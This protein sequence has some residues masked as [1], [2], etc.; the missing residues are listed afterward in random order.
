MNP[1]T[2]TAEAERTIDDLSALIEKLSGLMEQETA[3]VHAGKVSVAVGLGQTKSELAHQLYMSGER[4]RANAKFLLQS[5]P[6]RCAA[7]RFPAS[8][9]WPSKATGVRLCFPTI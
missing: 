9:P 4:L 3:L 2:T 8:P 7:V 5:V 1:I 6:A